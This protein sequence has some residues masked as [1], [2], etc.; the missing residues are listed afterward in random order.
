MTTSRSASIV[1]AAGGTGGHLFPAEALATELIGLG[2]SPVLVTDRRGGRFGGAVADIEVRIIHAGGL[3]G[4][5]WGARLVASAEL[6]AGFFE[7]KRLLARRRPDAVVGFGGYASVPTM[8]AASMS[9]LG[10]VL[11][12]QNAVLGRANRRL[13]LR[14]DRVAGAFAH[15]AMMPPQAAAKT[16]HVGMP[17]R[18]AFRSVGDRPYQPPTADGPVRILVL[19]GSQGARVLAEV[20]PEA[21]ARL[22]LSLR[23]RLAISQQCRPENL[24]SVRD[25]YAR[26]GVTADLSAFFGDVPERLTDAHIV[27]A[28]SGA[29]TVAELTAIGRPA[30]LVPYPHAIDDHQTANARAVEAAGA[31]WLMPEP[32]FT[33]AALADRLASR[34]ADTDNLT[35]T[36]AN[37][38]ALGIP[39]AARRLA[40]VV[41]DLAHRRHEAPSSGG[42]LAA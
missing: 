14:V 23:G 36:A 32:T 5:G 29:S 17:V 37:A 2:V 19:G 30:I 34:L 27:I 20:V 18:P 25:A 24:D 10:T 9:G 1:I 4:R 39:D 15:M 6:V 22:D 33:G 26:L 3:A 38:K 7:A 40:D 21:V 41:L 16:V 11:H 12:E 31:G 35:R 13:A 28:R 8:L 42:R